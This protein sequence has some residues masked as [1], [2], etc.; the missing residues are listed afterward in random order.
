MRDIRYVSRTIRGHIYYLVYYC[1]YF[2][3]SSLHPDVC[4]QDKVKVI[5]G[6]EAEKLRASLG[7]MDRQQR[8]RA[9]EAG[10]HNSHTYITTYRVNM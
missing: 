8:Q 1:L 7:I 3:C 6:E 10:K 4:R 5:Q 9:M 2:N